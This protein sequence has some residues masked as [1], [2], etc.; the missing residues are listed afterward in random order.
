[1]PGG[2]GGA[3]SRVR[4]RYP[5]FPDRLHPAQRC[6]V[7][8]AALG[9]P[10]GLAHSKWN[11]R[12]WLEHLPD[13]FGLAAPDEWRQIQADG[14]A[15]AWLYLLWAMLQVVEGHEGIVGRE[16]WPEARRFAAHTQRGIQSAARACGPRVSA[17]R[18][19]VARPQEIQLPGQACRQETQLKRGQP[20][21]AQLQ[22]T[23]PPDPARAADR[24]GWQ[25][26]ANLLRSPEQAGLAQAAYFMHVLHTQRR[27]PQ[28]D[29]DLPYST[30]RAAYA[31]V[32]RALAQPALLPRELQAVAGRVAATLGST[33]LFCAAGRHSLLARPQL[34]GLPACFLPAHV[35][36]QPPSW[37]AV[38]AAL[39]AAAG[40]DRPAADP[41]DP[42]DRADRADCV[43]ALGQVHDLAE[44]VADLFADPLLTLRLQRPVAGPTRLDRLSWALAKDGRRRFERLQCNSAAA[45][46]AHPAERPLPAQAEPTAVAPPPDE[47]E[48]RRRIS[49]LRHY[50]ESNYLATCRALLQEI[51]PAAA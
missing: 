28:P 32:L 31:E 19:T 47:L 22:G 15:P 37:P 39:A 49:T 46:S 51:S 14:G 5:D 8:L 3:I 23:V 45:A 17:A 29:W 50:A 43:A 21:E 38:A 36:S 48:T 20:E 42:A 7:C 6:H 16:W 27:T 9:D 41:A 30:R 24:A 13:W 40:Q 2:H 33:A 26:A 25:R 18:A 1:M 11:R 12:A 34:Q 4:L 44:A 10:M 35:R